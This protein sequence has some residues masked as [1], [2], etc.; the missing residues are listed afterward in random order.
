MRRT[1]Q[2]PQLQVERC[3]SCDLTGIVTFAF[4]QFLQHFGTS[5]ITFKQY[6]NSYYTYSNFF[7]IICYFTQY[8]LSQ[9][10]KFG[11]VTV[12]CHE[13]VIGSWISLSPTLYSTRSA[14]LK[15]FTSSPPCRPRSFLQL[16]L[17]HSRHR[18]L[19]VASVLLL[20]YVAW[21]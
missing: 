9:L 11:G 21:S 20:T 12:T 15:Y 2:V 17:S 8:I 10:S 18:T 7:G 13:H 5:L 6:I 4:Q 14:R 19:T 16:F 3:K 1:L